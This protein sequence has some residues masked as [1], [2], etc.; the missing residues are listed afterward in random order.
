M[1]DKNNA[2]DDLLVY[3]RGEFV[4]ESEDNLN[5]IE[6]LL[7]NVRSGQEQADTAIN[8]ILRPSHSLK[9]SAS[10][11]D[12]PLVSVIMHRLED[13]LSGL[14]TLTNEHIEA[15]Q[16]FVDKAREYSSLS[17]DQHKISTADL[18][19]IL[20]DRHATETAGNAAGEQRIVEAMMIT[21]EKT[22]GLI[23]ERELRAAG[24]RV[25]TVRS[26][27]EAIE[28][29]VRTR[30]D[31]IICSGVLDILSGVDI[32]CAM[33]AMPV[34]QD[35]PICLL[36]SFEKGHHEL[37]GLREDVYLIQKTMLKDDLHHV[38]EKYGL[39]A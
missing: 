16:V 37:K 28:M 19:R 1:S 12:F 25:T 20:P 17:V 39:F 8:L 10:V 32:S 34:T 22:A 31:L 3:L 26:S 30:P 9:G 15:V 24:L 7:E 36:T 23:F 21:R 13:Y 2:Y 11:A 35:I 14:K 33:K 27:F 5:S 4:D 29:A 6:I 18:V 38:L